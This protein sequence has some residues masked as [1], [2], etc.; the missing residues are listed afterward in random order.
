MT[1]VTWTSALS[2]NAPCPR[3][4]HSMVAVD[5]RLFLFGGW[6]SGTCLGDL[7]VYDTEKTTTSTVSVSTT[8]KAASSEA[9]TSSSSSSSSL[10]V[11]PTADRDVNVPCARSEH[12]AF[13]SGAQLF[14]YGGID[15]TGKVLRDI[16]ALNL[17]FLIVCPRTCGSYN[18]LYT[19]I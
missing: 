14:I 9:T 5:R 16:H 13:S 11:P 18:Y 3:Q 8:T 15:A 17:G 1:T 2:A 10:V 4:G 19:Y 12:C 6:S 7:C